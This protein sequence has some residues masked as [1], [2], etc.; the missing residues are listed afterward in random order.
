[1]K[2]LHIISGVLVCLLAMMGTASAEG[3]D[4]SVCNVNGGTSIEK[5]SAT[6]GGSEIIVSVTDLTS[7][8]GRIDKVGFVLSPFTTAT[9]V[10]NEGNT[11][12]PKRDNE[13]SNIGG[14]FGEY[15]EIVSPGSKATS[16]TITF[17]GTIT[18]TPKLAAHVAWGTNSA[19]FSGPA[20]DTQIPEFPTVALPVAAILGLMFIL[21]RRKEN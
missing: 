9:V 4:L 14:G 11:W 21:Q 6:Y 8:V 18:G 15:Y 17:S 2:T 19:Y 10:D 12:N 16:V 13:M 5:V 20:G 7:A 3:F 1:M